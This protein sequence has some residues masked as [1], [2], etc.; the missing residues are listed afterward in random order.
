MDRGD[1]TVDSAS[2]AVLPGQA[3]GILLVKYSRM[4]PTRY[5]GSWADARPSGYGD[6][7][8]QDWKKC[9]IVRVSEG[10]R[11]LTG[12]QVALFAMGWAALARRC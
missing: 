5:D 12:K 4:D 3:G 6:R 10:V 9:W 7:S 2:A 11:D 1:T 8:D